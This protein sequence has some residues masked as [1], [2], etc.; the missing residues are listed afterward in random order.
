MKITV[1]KSK[2]PVLVDNNTLTLVKENGFY[3]CNTDRGYIILKRRVGIRGKTTNNNTLYKYEEIYLHRYVTKC[4]K[5]MYVDHI[6]GNKLNNQFSNL[7]ICTNSENLRNR[8]KVS[9]NYKGVYFDSKRNK[10][11]SQ[12][13]LNYKRHYLGHFNTE[14]EAAVAYNNKARILHGSFA[15]LNIL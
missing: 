2:L 8:K 6:D 7:R 14:K 11:T 3:M 5:G 12:I 9:G 4:P 10:W 1:G 13:T 15:N